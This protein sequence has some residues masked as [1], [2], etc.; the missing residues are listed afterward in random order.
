MAFVNDSS[1]NLRR[2]VASNQEHG[3]RGSA[4][5]IQEK[6]GSKLRRDSD[7]PEV[8]RGFPQSLL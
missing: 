3:T 4:S 8:F 7:Y 6:P 1:M 5:D 2:C